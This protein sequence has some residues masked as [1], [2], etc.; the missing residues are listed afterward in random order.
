M[1][2]YSSE[3]RRRLVLDDGGES[4]PGSTYEFLCTCGYRIRCGVS[5]YGDQLGGLVFFDDEKT[6][7]TWGEEMEQCPRCNRRLDLPGLLP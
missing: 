1:R 6:S 7:R 4:S 3:D 2:Q 5:R